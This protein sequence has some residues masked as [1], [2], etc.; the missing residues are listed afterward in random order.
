VGGIILSQKKCTERLTTS[1]SGGSQSSL[2]LNLVYRETAGFRLLDAWVSFCLH[3]LAHHSVCL[4]TLKALRETWTTKQA[5]NPSTQTH[6]VRDA[7][8][9]KKSPRETAALKEQTT[10]GDRREIRF[11]LWR[12]ARCDIGGS[13]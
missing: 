12:S 13:S 9:A 6:H 5:R 4:R 7:S 11:L 3:M 2:G 1:I 8:H 10:L